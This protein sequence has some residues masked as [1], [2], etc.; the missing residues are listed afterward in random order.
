MSSPCQTMRSR[1]NGYENSAD[2]VQLAKA[3]RD[4]VMSGKFDFPGWRA[5]AIELGGPFGG[6]DFTKRGLIGRVSKA[7]LDA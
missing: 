5:E 2:A 4:G 1:C 7:W 3:Q 6:C